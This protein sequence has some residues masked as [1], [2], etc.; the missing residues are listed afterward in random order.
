M[1][2]F[3]EESPYKVGFLSKKEITDAMELEGAVEVDVNS[4][5]VKERL[6]QSK[7]GKVAVFCRR[8]KT[9]DHFYI[10]VAEC[11]NETREQIKNPAE[12]IFVIGA[13]CGLI[14]R[15]LIDP[16]KKERM[17]GRFLLCPTSK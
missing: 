17:P 5:V 4:E 8:F 7:D 2:G 12:I 9:S 15:L 10:T 6:R 3:G 14:K 16:Y 13:R 11:P 1:L